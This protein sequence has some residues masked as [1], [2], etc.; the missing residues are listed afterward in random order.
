MPMLRKVAVAVVV[1][2]IAAAAV[3]WVLTMPSSVP[4]STLTPHTADLANGKELFSAGGC[5]SCH[6]T[7]Q[8]KDKT[9]LGGGL[10]LATPFGTF[11]VPNISSDKNDGIG[12][13]TEAQFVTALTKGTS[14]TGE[15]Y[16]PAFPY[17]TYAHAKIDDLRD[18]FAYLKT[19]PAVAGR[20]PP[21]ALS[22]PFNIRR[23]LGL[24]KWMFLD[25]APFVPDVSKPAAWNR[26]AYL[27]NAFA[28][29]AECHSPR[30]AMGGIIDGQ[31]F[32]GGVA[33]NGKDWVPNITQKGIG[34][35][36]EKD[37][38]TMLETAD[39]PDGDSVGGDMGSVVGNTSLLT[40]QDR[41]AIAAYIK[42]LA[43]V[44]GPKPP[45]PKG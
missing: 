18:L 28:H 45:E 19:L 34:D 11:H 25:T 12:G 17:T 5:A 35:W 3:F 8:Q 42:S 1:L 33:A 38:A 20:A 23:G 10:A 6:A 24:W 21:H 36:S 39:K 27:V 26:G 31:R 30:N 15:H 13:W 44:I 32:A 9:R 40:V 7:P 14:P 2:V 22:F 41:A 37:I 4:A 29:C 16:Y 43:P